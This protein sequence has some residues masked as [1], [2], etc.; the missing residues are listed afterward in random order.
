MVPL[1]PHVHTVTVLKDRPQSEHAQ[2]L[3]HDVYRSVALLMRENSLTVGTL[4]EF[5]PKQHNLLGLNV[6]RGARIL[7]RLRHHT[8]VTQFLSRDQVLQTMLHELTHN[9]IGPHND[10]FHKQLKIW[11]D[12][13][14]VIDTLGLKENFLGKGKKLGGGGVKFNDIR[15]KRVQKLN[16]TRLGTGSNSPNQEI[17]LTPSQRARTA[18]LQRW[19]SNDKIIT[20]D[21]QS[22]VDDKLNDSDLK[23][24][25]DEILSQ[26]D[27]MDSKEIIDLTMDEQG[28]RLPICIDLTNE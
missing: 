19:T 13:Q 4:A 9:L 14:Y 7:L 26:H 22:Q 10:K 28:Q 27:S 16:G 5:Y 2:W 12:R 18:A 17:M 24:N 20:R 6:N 8:D 3:L 21:R 25:I 11:S 23:V 15:L 1:N